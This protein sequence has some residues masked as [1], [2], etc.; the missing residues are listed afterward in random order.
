MYKQ[1]IIITCQPDDSYFIWQNEMYIKSCIQRGFKEENIHILLYNPPNRKLNNNWDKLKNR[2]PKINIYRY[3]DKGEGISKY[4]SLYIPILRP[5]LLWQHFEKYPELSKEVILYTD[6]DILWTENL[7][8]FK[9]FNDNICYISDAKSYMNF[10]YFSQKEK[11]ILGNKIKEYENRDILK[12]LCSFVGISKDEIRENNNNT[13]G[14]QYIL[15]NINSSFWKKVQEDV[16]KI[17]VHLMNINKEFYKSENHGIQSWCSDLWAVLWNLWYTGKETKVVKEMDF[18]WS[19]D[20]IE[21]LNT[22][23]IL[24]NAGVVADMHGDTPMFYKGKYHQGKDPL[25]D[26]YL[27]TVLNNEKNQKLCNNYYLKEL[28]NLKNNGKQT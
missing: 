21:K 6:S 2:F 12:E 27:F 1:P 8:I 25:E 4:L 28:L 16:L 7:D 14:V 13:G 24:H 15:K 9:L 23:G 20:P 26:P 18:A 19:T 10:D 17:R 5:H 11:E 3:S 22:V